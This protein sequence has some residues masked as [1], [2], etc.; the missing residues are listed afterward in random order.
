MNYHMDFIGI[1]QEENIY[2]YTYA[3]RGSS[4]F[5]KVFYKITFIANYPH[6]V[7]TDIEKALVKEGF[8]FDVTPQNTPIDLG[9]GSL[10]YSNFSKDD[11][12]KYKTDT[13]YWS[14]LKDEGCEKQLDLIH[15]YS[16]KHGTPDL[17]LPE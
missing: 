12:E 13:M 8:I 5:K 2:V 14:K 10:Q 1:D 15:K 11:E 9:F 4:L 6:Y 16:D 7:W 17:K 3:A